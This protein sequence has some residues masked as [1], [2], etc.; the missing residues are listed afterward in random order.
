[1]VFDE[2]DDVLAGIKVPPEDPQFY[3]RAFSVIVKQNKEIMSRENS[4]AFC[5]EEYDNLSKR[6]DRS[7]LQ[8]SCSVRNVLRTRCLANNLINDKGEISLERIPE[9]INSLKE[10][11]YSLGP[12]RQY[13]AV[14]QEHIL[15]TLQFLS[16][17]KDAQRLL[18][19]ISKPISDPHA[20][21]FIRATLQLPQK[22]TVTDA[23]TRRAALAS[24]LCYLR[25]NVGSCFA[26]A[27][28]I[29]VHD[30]QPLQYLK[31]INEI[32]STGR[33]KR[34]FGGVEYTSPLSISWG[35]G[36]LK[37]NILVPLNHAN[38]I[39]L[40]LWLSPGLVAAFE[41]TGL[42][43][44]EFS[45]KQKTE[46]TKDLISQALYKAEN[47]ELY[48]ITNAED[49]IRRVLLNHL[50][51]SES[52]LKDYENRSRGTLQNVM[53]TPYL[54]TTPRGKTEICTTFYHLL[55][56]AEDAFKGLADNALLKA[57][58]FTM[59]SFAETKAGFTRWN[60][61][62]SLGFQH[63]ERGGVGFCMY[64]IIV[65]KIEQS[66]L[67]IKDLQ[68]EYEVMY[69]QI[70]YLEL[71]LQR[72]ASEK[73]LE[74]LK[75]DYK[76]KMYAFNTLEELR[77]NE[78]EK[79]QRI[80]NMFNLLSDAYYELFPKY[81]QEVYDADMHEVTVG[82]YDDSPAGFR[83]LFKHGRA[84]TSQW[85]YIRNPNDFIQA[86]SDFFIA[87]ETELS[88][89]EEFKGL[90][91]ELTEIVTSIVMQVKTEEFLE[92]AFHRMAAVHQ[93]RDFKNPLANLDKI[94]K[95]PW[96]YTSGGSMATL[97]SCFFGLE[98][99]PFEVSR[100]VENPMELL[101][102]LIDTIKQ[103]PHKLMSE[104]TSKA[105]KS[106]LIH[107][108]THAFLMKPGL[109]P[110]KEGW[111]DDSFTYT[112]VRDNMVKPIERF[113]DNI[114]L[115]ESAQEF[116]IS[117]LSEFVPENF[118]YYFRQSFSRL[119]GDMSPTQL[120]NHIVE[121]MQ[122]ERGLQF[123]KTL[124]LQPDE[125]DRYLYEVLPIFPTFQM[126]ERIKEVVESISEI[127]N[128][129]KERLLIL[130]NKLP[131]VIGGERYATSKMLQDTIKA[132]LCLDLQKTSMPFD[133]HASVIEGAR[134]CDYAFPKPILFADTNW[135]KDYFGFTVNPGSGKLELWRFDILGIIGTP[136]SSWSQWLDGTRRDI[137]WGIYTRPYEYIK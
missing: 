78:N 11:L 9:I 57:W 101:V 136:M 6:L 131:S 80:A 108:P 81:F 75:I 13:D 107:S 97:V 113:I 52:D 21:E 25:Q 133:F 60:L 106:M 130:W 132:L 47:K 87:T 16:I 34:T 95:K 8:E 42:L 111:L 49:I 96:A 77:D 89:R 18:K 99:K 134:K 23:H 28:A 35:A 68:E 48:L 27:P 128:A 63:E 40:E 45:L 61:Y 36:D 129:Q 14:R 56:L 82:Q 54:Q 12:N 41:A 37:K 124:V 121:N 65:Q 83:L 103:V 117:K 20:E 84:N 115:D 72:A 1:V 102:F 7:Q 109:S 70:K 110:F 100:W 17:S 58:E 74:W 112:W 86:L 122:K 85:T 51:L 46:M 10:S 125:I 15:N 43:K 93:S 39:E 123:H 114:V 59:A 105:N 116:I 64:E 26:T 79:A 22:E 98:D 33:L 50:H 67:K 118:R 90:D 32:L 120:R 73:E 53:L 5:G 126:N 119:H 31:D 2:I 104:Y 55:D 137:S 30:E 4:R 19:A 88:S 44:K 71:R 94:E 62:S 3:P 24:W 66:K 91:R 135:T 127:P 92:T 69:S 29:I 38:E 76:T